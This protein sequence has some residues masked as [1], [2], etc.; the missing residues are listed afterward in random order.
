MIKSL[1]S[2]IEK[3]CK[4]LHDTDAIKEEIYKFIEGCIV[5][6]IIKLLE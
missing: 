6:R 3:F 1:E 5:R 4:E 2:A